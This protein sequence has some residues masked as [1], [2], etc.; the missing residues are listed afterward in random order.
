MPDAEPLFTGFAGDRRVGAGPLAVVA[1]AL[2]TAIDAGETGQKSSFSTTPTRGRSKST[3][4]ALTRMSRPASGARSSRGA[5]SRRRRP[6]R[7][8]AGPAVRSSACSRAR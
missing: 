5:H 2:K 6:T 1:A 3:F 7:R 4:A 8:G